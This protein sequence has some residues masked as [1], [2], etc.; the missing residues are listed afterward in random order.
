MVSKPIFLL[1]SNFLSCY[2][3][4]ILFG[5]FFFPTFTLSYCLPFYTNFFLTMR[6]RPYFPT[7]SIQNFFL[8]LLSTTMT[9]ASS[10]IAVR[11][12]HA[13]ITTAAITI[14]NSIT[15]KLSKDNYRLWKATI[16][17]ILKGHFVYGFVNGII[18]PPPQ[19]I[20]VV[21]TTDGVETIKKKSNPEYATWNQ[22]DQLILGAFTSSL[23]ESTLTY[24]LKCT[25]S[26]D[27]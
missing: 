6:I 1:T 21:S 4:P 13:T 22:Q 8:S 25:T 14:H 17:P 26:C 11:T 5:I 20:E 12:P 2:L 10:S 19:T 15:H 27:L 3:L 23:T 24:V 7:F 9:D 16:M 18:K